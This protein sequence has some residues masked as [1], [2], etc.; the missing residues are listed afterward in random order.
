MLFFYM[1]ILLVLNFLESREVRENLEVYCKVVDS[2]RNIGFR[3]W[4]N[5]LFIESIINYWGF[6]F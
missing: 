3:S 5:D 4:N 1:C 2:G 6:C